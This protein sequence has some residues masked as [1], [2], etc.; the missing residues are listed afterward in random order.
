MKIT[1]SNNVFK[2][3]KTLIAGAAILALG[4]Q[5]AL[6]CTGIVLHAQDGT[7]VP[8]RTMEFGFDVQSNIYAVPAGTSIETLVLDKDQTG[9]T[10]E[11]KYGFLGANG[12]DMPI[13]F[14]GL[15]TEGLYFGAF[16]FAGD[17]VFGT[18]SDANRDHA[19][20]SEELGNWIL[21]QFATVDEVKA[22]LPT[23]EVVGTHIDALRGVAP[24]HY[25]VTDATGASI[26]IEYT[27]DGLTIHDNTVNAMTNNPP[28]DWHLTNLRNYIGLQ[29]E[30]VPEI[31]VGRQTLQPYGQ[32][33]GMAGLPGD[34]TSPS[35]FVR[36]VAF[37]NTTLPAADASEAIFN[38]FHIL[39]AFDIPKG[40][41]REGHDDSLQTDYTIWTSASDTKNV[42]Y[43][44][45]TYQTQAVESID[46]R[47]V[48]AKITK[49][50]TLEMEN[51]F[52]INDRTA[53]F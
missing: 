28:Y 5:S 51:G 31:T 32:G 9:F 17:A 1:T 3:I 13:V 25:G 44:Y 46:V 39:N 22:A 42:Q 19:V 23:I 36:A 45:K 16:Y 11:A 40:A 15:N 34:F 10:F 26:V 18:V 6:A 2:S 53:D 4:T 35:R 50:T 27:V 12:L 29:A 21:G 41:V 8:A 37:A 47:K 20:S 33:T 30:N 38:A 43:Y 48:I 7:V 14:D 49:P 52:V 24:F